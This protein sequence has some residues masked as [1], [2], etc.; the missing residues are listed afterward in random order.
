MPFC[1][2]DS[3]PTYVY[4]PQTHHAI[5]PCKHA[6]AQR[7]RGT[8]CMDAQQRARAWL[9]SQGKKKRF[10]RRT[11][12]ITSIIIGIVITSY[13]VPPVPLPEKPT[14]HGIVGFPSAKTPSLRHPQ[15]AQPPP[16]ASPASTTFAQ[17]PC[18]SYKDRH[19]SQPQRGEYNDVVKCG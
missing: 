12:V 6:N 4:T 14:S 11:I 19:R 8:C 7:H 3:I 9:A 16:P 18:V 1:S 17:P 10:S 5:I 15:G 2:H 13:L